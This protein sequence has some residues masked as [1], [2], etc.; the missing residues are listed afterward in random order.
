MIQGLFV[1][2]V[3]YI[4]VTLAW[5]NAVKDYWFTLDT[6]FTGDLQIPYDLAK[7]LG[8][9]IT[10]VVPTKIANGQTE[11]VPHATAIAVMEG[12]ANLM[13]VGLSN[14]SPLA[15]ITFLSKFG[16]KITVDCVHRSVILEKTF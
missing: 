15:G 12:V 6:G 11:Q 5:N 10:S 1:G 8:M 9:M 4:K 16:Y 3:P 2:N 14:G 7:E 13:Q